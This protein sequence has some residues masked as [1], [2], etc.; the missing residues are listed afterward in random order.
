MFGTSMSENDAYGASDESDEEDNEEIIEPAKVEVI[1][2][3]QLD[4]NKDK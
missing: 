1:D 4:K 3:E 2:P